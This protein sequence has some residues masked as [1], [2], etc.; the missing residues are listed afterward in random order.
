M[1]PFSS[2]HIGN[3]Y[4]HSENVVAV[5]TMT[6]LILAN[7]FSSS[8]LC[9]KSLSHKPKNTSNKCK[10]LSV[11]ETGKDIF[12]VRIM[13]FTLPFSN[14]LPQYVQSAGNPENGRPKKPSMETS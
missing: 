2:A 8:I 14:A 9:I 13:A 1:C 11:N 7:V 6:Q 10:N 12:W 5:T 4:C 3:V